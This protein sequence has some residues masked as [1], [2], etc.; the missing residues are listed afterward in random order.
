VIAY[1]A[2]Y[3]SIANQISQL[4]GSLHQKIDAVN[5]DLTA[6][7]GKID[8]RATK[9]ES[10]VKALGDNQSNPL[11][12]LIHDLLAAAT[13]ALPNKPEVA[14]RVISVVDSLLVTMK[15]ERQPAGAE[16][17]RNTVAAINELSDRVPRA[18]PTGETNRHELASA[19]YSAKV[20]LAEYRSALEPTPPIAGLSWV[21]A[22]PDAAE[23]VVF[24]GRPLTLDQVNFDL[25][26]LGQR[27]GFKVNPPL[28]GL[29]SEHVTI[30]NAYIKGGSNV[31]DGIHWA[32]VVFIGSHI[33]YRGGEVELRNVRF[34]NCSF[35]VPRS[36]QGAKLVNYAALA[37]QYLIV[38]G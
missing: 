1:V 11:K 27:T 15:K 24:I 29:L 26:F 38:P 3:I 8:T 2:G 22:T 20:S 23:D 19:V 7:V 33:V 13:N 10:A 31:L 18:R 32:N 37:T 21:I 4:T 36:D 16:Y 14:A 28:K 17:F 5:R 35:E 12:G 30:E 34:V 6:Q 9:L 25:T